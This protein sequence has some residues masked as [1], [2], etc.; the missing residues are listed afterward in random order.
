MHIP[1]GR[2]SAELRGLEP[3]HITTVVILLILKLEDLSD[4]VDDSIFFS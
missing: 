2:L 1:E 3:V 4:G